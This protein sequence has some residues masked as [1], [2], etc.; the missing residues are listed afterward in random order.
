[1]Y[2]AWWHLN[3]QV[4]GIPWT[5]GVEGVTYNAAKAKVFLAQGVAEFKKASDQLQKAYGALTAIG[6]AAVFKA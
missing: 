2:N 6:G 4:Y 1:M 3:G 5:W